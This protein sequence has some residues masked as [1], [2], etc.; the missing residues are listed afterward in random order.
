M[1]LER[2]NG[3]QVDHVPAEGPKILFVHGASAGSWNW[4]TFLHFFA[5]EGYDCYALNLRGHAPNP[6][7]ADLGQVSMTDYAEDVR[8]V[9][10]ELGG[11]VVLIG[12]SMG[13][14]IAQ[15][16]AQDTPL[17]A[18]VFASSA[19]VAGVKFQNPP[20]NVWF[21]L[22]IF[23]S[24]PA[25]V[26]KKPLKPGFKV[27]KTAVFNRVEPERQR[28]LFEKMVPE[29][30]VAGVEVLK[31]EVSADLS[32]VNFPLLVI[33]GTDDQTSVIAME[34]EIAQQHR[35][36][37]IEL[38]GHGHMFMLE[39]GWEQTARKLLEWLRSKGI[40]ARA[41]AAEQA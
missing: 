19:P 7:L 13:G 25:M 41:P 24:L 23:K 8:G 35:A 31:G 6:P 3:L 20:F 17:R 15:L 9:L 40:E 28:E 38:P 26:R 27:S 14:G 21:L 32:A 33:S 12:H 4:E 37:L 34:R 10:R 5:A 39:P 36:D 30:A 11:D 22:H 18:A 16:V 29:S 1:A 2:I